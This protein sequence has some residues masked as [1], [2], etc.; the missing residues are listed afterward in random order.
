MHVIV[1]EELYDRQ[2]IEGDDRGLRGDS[3]DASPPTS[4]PRRWHRDL[5]DRRR[6][7]C[8]T[9]RGPLPN[10]QGGHDLLG[11]GR[12]PAHPRHRQL[13][14]PDLA[15]ADLTGHVRA[16]GLG[17]APA[18][19]A[20]QRAGCLGCWPDPACSCR[21][22]SRSPMMSVRSS[23]SSTRS[24]TRATEIG[25]AEGSD[26]GRDHRRD[27]SPSEIK[28]H[29]RAWV[30]TRP[31]R[32]RMSSTPAMRWPSW[33][34]LV[35]QDIFLT[36]TANYRRC[37]P[38][39][40][41]RGPEKTGTVTNTNRQVQMGRQGAGCR[42]RVRRSEDWLDHRRSWRAEAGAGLGYTTRRP[43]GLQRK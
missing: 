17:P 35:V 32:T 38:A 20:E 22:T 27:L 13:A 40:L 2:Y 14:L 8:A 23:S 42:L 1:E 7:C 15:G 31:C 3:E 19:W 33:N 4:R 26:R 24:G 30:R 25:S 9:W 36:E 16:S 28:G 43:H 41:A 11:H 12:Q 18:A 29:L 21:T 37:D 39:C 10:A 34:H 5:R 6:T